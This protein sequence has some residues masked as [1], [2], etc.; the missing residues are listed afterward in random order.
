MILE[1]YWWD[2]SCMHE[3]A[4][5]DKIEERLESCYVDA[6]FISQRIIWCIPSVSASRRF[7][8]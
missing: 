7:F 3:S 6:T 5:A 1:S 4:E 2:E 8:F